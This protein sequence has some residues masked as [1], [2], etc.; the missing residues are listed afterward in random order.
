[1]ATSHLRL[2]SELVR[3]IA[4]YINDLPSL[5]AF[6]RTSKQLFACAKPNL[7]RTVQITLVYR[8]DL[9]PDLDDLDSPDD[10]AESDTGRDE[11]ARVYRYSIGTL[12]LLARLEGG[13]E[14]VGLVT[15]V[16][17]CRRQWSGRSQE[18]GTLRARWG[19]TVA[20]M[21]RLLPHVT[22]YDFSSWTLREFPVPLARCPDHIAKLK[23][24]WCSSAEWLIVRHLK[25]LK[26]LHVAQLH[27]PYA[28]PHLNFLGRSLVTLNLGSA[29]DPE[30][31][32][33]I[34]Q[35]QPNLA[36]LK[37]SVL[38]LPFMKIDLFPALAHLRK[39]FPES[40]VRVDVG[41]APSLDALMLYIIP[42]LTREKSEQPAAQIYLRNSDLGSDYPEG[43][44]HLLCVKTVCDA[45]NI[46]LLLG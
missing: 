9:A 31:I 22:C 11:P 45:R 3:Q 4:G 19:E 35:S 30:D 18:C 29:S 5:S 37:L 15:E 12:N 20:A 17:F 39:K 6:S 41:F 32:V 27:R 10:T 43:S 16:H 2:P 34:R 28:M 14:I 7:Y 13:S 46:D 1:M 42:A 36:V 23:I 26:T 24:D 21:G 25:Q 38:S 8:V 33:C 40:L 44:D